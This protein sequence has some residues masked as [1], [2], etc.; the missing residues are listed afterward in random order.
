MTGT[1]GFAAPPA[2]LFG[3]CQEQGPRQV[4]WG[5]G[6]WAPFFLLAEQT[7]SSPPLAGLMP[8]LPPWVRSGPLWG[9]LVGLLLVYLYFHVVHWNPRESVVAY[10][11]QVS[12]N[13]DGQGPPPTPAP[14]EPRAHSPVFFFCL[15]VASGFS[16][17]VSPNLSPW[18]RQE[19]LCMNRLCSRICSQAFLKEVRTPPRRLWAGGGNPQKKRVERT[20]PAPAA[21]GSGLLQAQPPF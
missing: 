3:H 21:K 15:C 13:D 12:Q 14:R 20:P 7:P 8:D 5:G 16:G 17:A 1:I 18:F 2:K 11:L 19:C 9:T 4:V 10:L 6:T